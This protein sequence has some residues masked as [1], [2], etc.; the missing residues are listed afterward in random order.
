MAF[1][2]NKAAGEGMED[3]DRSVLGLP[4][5]S[6]IQKGSPEFDE[7]H[8]DYAT[9]G[10][11]DC[12]PGMLLFAPEHRILKQPLEVIPLAQRTLYTEWKPRKGGFV[13]NRD[14]TI[15]DH[16]NYRKGPIGSKEE[17]KEWFGDNELVRTIYYAV[18]F[19]D[20]D[21]WKQ[22][23]IGFT[24]TGLKPA[25]IW[26]K[27]IYNV[28]FDGHPNVQAPVY[29]AIWNIG[30]KAEQNEAGGWFNWDIRIAKV[31]N[32]E[33]DEALLTVGQTSRIE[34]DQKLLPRPPGQAQ[35]AIAPGATQV[36]DADG[37]P[38]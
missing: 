38:Y 5:I 36:V 17:N 23:L 21:M 33:T 7:T 9:K 19:R 18:L 32:P 29:A 13:G 25:R 4:F 22:G 35:K 34:A 24:S 30:T 31:L 6:L 12:K 27:A 15:V 11:K 20:G 1:D 26:G 28:R 8:K 2:I 3:F 10:I 37:N 14:L 16:P